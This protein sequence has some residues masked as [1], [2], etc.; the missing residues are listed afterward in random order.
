MYFI[1]LHDKWWKENEEKKVTRIYSVKIACIGVRRLVLF[2]TRK[3]IIIVTHSFWVNFSKK[4]WNL[5][6]LYNVP[7]KKW[8][9]SFRLCYFVHFVESHSTYIKRTNFG[10]WISYLCI[11][12]WFYFVEGCTLCND[13]LW[14]KKIEVKQQ[15]RRPCEVTIFLR[16]YIDVWI[17][18]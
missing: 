15:L 16:I 17:L 8:N 9:I 13:Q 12:K 14:K 10:I 4:K 2:N 7:K 1:T 6:L 3:K 11:M 18:R 5:F